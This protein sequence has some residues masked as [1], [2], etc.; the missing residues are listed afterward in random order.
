[1][2]DKISI[3]IQLI[4]A[5]KIL[6]AGDL[7]AKAIEWGSK[8]TDSR[9]KALNEWMA[10]ENL[11]LMNDGKVPT[12]CRN[13]LFSNPDVTMCSENVAGTVENWRVLDEIESLSDHLY[14]SYEVGNRIEETPTTTGRKWNV[15]KIDS[16]RLIQSFKQEMRN[17]T[18]PEEL[19]K[20]LE[21]ACT[22]GMPVKKIPQ[23]N[24][25]YWWN[26]SVKEARKKCI[27]ARRKYTRRRRVD[28]GSS[29]TIALH[30]TYADA[31]K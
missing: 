15:Q 18:T 23:K 17:I 11:T 25:V 28:A 19:M 6:V 24:K 29:V 8:F 5:R 26:D 3:E 7:N 20:V 2:L 22:H 27:K 21:T 31:R 13:E 12:F 10:T 9:G 4:D 16:A 1:M 14:I 30:G